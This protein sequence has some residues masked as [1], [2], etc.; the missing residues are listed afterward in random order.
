MLLLSTSTNR[1]RR[2]KKSARSKYEPV[3]LKVSGT[4]SSVAAV[5]DGGVVPVGVA[6]VVVVDVVVVPPDAWS[7]LLLAVLPELTALPADS[8]AP[9]TP[10]C[11]GAPPAAA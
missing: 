2:W 7:T 3:K 5:V 4:V 9:P 1:L 10:V 8:V 6:V 11:A